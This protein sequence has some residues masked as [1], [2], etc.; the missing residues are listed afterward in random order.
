[1]SE[2]TKK[3]ET[4]EVPEREVVP[5]TCRRGGPQGGPCGH[6][7]AYRNE[8]PHG[9]TQFQCTACGGT[10]MVGLGREVDF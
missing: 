3:P 9:N 10:W 8:L 5:M 2:D 1:M 4:P 6:H 7:Q